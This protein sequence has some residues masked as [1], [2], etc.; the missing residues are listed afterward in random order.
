MKM[1]MMHHLT[2]LL[3]VVLALTASAV[4]FHGNS[5]IVGPE[6]TPS[7]EVKSS[8][9]TSFARQVAA[10][11]ETVD[12]AFYNYIGPWWEYYGEEILPMLLQEAAEMKLS[13]Q[14]IEWEY[15][16]GNRY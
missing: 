16:Y 5:I 9:V 6:Q 14:K 3:C 8:E 11:A 4:P 2:V 10:D 13:S 15:I 12:D 7:P 1:M